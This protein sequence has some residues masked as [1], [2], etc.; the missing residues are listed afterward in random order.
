M[1]KRTYEICSITEHY[2]QENVREH[3]HIGMPITTSTYGNSP[4]VPV[5]NV[6]N[7]FIMVS[8]LVGTTSYG[9]NNLA[10]CNAILE[11]NLDNT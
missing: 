4:A 11:V 1:S 8:K 6:S 2:T 9:E 7:Q 3:S 10:I 5:R